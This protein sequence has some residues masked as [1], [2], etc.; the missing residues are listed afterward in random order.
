MT[1]GELPNDVVTS[2]LTAWSYDNHIYV[3]GGFIADYTAVST[4][5]KLDMSQDPKTFNDMKY[6]LLASSS[7][8]RGDI[9]AVT[10]D[11]YA[12]MAGGLTHTSLWC[13]GLTTTERYHMDSNTWET[14]APLNVGRADMA[15]AILNGKIISLGGETKPEDCKDVQDPAYGSFPED[16][17]EVLLHSHDDPS[18]SE[19]V[20]FSDFKDQRF[21]FAAAVVPSQN[22]L[23]TFGGQLPFDFTC[24]C[25]PTDD[26]IG[27]ATEVFTT[28][29]TTDKS[30]TTTT[31]DSST[32]TLGGGWIAFIVI[33][34]LLGAFIIFMVI[35]TFVLKH[36][37]EEIENKAAEDFVAPNNGEADLE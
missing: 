25:F 7:N 15:V 6:T 27:I 33:M 2:D 35:R 13:E 26:K 9:H 29:V 22:R 8:A 21:R 4:T 1:H 36:N 24:D 3:T 12:Y 37:K 23:Y 18:T 28:S 17:V 30:G 14:L 31:S 34:T 5:Y 16:H 19:W 10:L 20:F 11:G 32:T